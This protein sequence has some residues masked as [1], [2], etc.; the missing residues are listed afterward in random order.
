MEAR[1][2][3]GIDGAFENLR[4]VAID[5][6]LDDAGPDAGRGRPRRRLEIARLLCGSHPHPNEA[7]GFAA[8]I[9]RVAYRFHGR[10]VARL[11]GP[12]YHIALDVDLPSVI[13]A[14]KPAI[15]VAAERERG[16][17]VWAMLVEHTQPTATVTKRDQVLAQQPHAH[18]LA[19]GF[20]DFLQH[21][22][23]NPMATH[24]LSHRSVTFDAAKQLVFV[25]T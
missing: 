20:C 12:I 21:A 13:K 11:R 24:Q 6:N 10:H 9:G 5:L 15:F 2:V 22:R 8:W 23:W 7:T 3:R 1:A 16:S 14:T 25:G 19:V 18:G 4:P 17:P